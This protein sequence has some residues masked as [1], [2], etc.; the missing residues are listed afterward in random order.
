MDKTLPE[1]A[2]QYRQDPH[3]RNWCWYLGK[4]PSLILG[5]LIK[6]TSWRWHQWRGGATKMRMTEVKRHDRL[7]WPS[8]RHLFLKFIIIVAIV[9]QATIS[10]KYASALFRV[11][12]KGRS[13]LSLWR[14]KISHSQFWLVVFVVQM[15]LE[16]EASIGLDLGRALKKVYTSPSQMQ[17]ITTIRGFLFTRDKFPCPCPTLT[18]LWWW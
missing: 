8:P 7:I 5:Y 15:S 4:I 11:K 14:V 9:L 10:Q 18:Q 1:I 2:S 12:T 6:L 17:K 16:Q 3:I 13:V